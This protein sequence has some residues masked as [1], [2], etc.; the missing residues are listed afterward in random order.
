MCKVFF[1]SWKGEAATDYVSKRGIFDLELKFKLEAPGVD[2]QKKIG[3]ESIGAS[4]GIIMENLMDLRIG[5]K[6]DMKFNLL[7]LCV[8][9]QN[10][11]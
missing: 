11:K 6:F 8:I 1:F 3:S 2:W 5:E 9:L 7:C 10:E 4:F